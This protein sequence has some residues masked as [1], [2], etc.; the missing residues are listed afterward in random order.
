MLCDRSRGSGRRP[1]H[2]MRE[3]LRRGLQRGM[4]GVGSRLL[5][6]NIGTYMDGDKNHQL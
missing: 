5:W 2:R 6:M 1:R 4:G 3:W